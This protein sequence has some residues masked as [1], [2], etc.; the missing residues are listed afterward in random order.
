MRWRGFLIWGG[1]AVAAIALAAGVSV[2]AFRD[3]LSRYSL[4]PS[5]EFDA[6]RAPKAPDY[7]TDQAWVQLPKAPLRDAD[8]FFLYPT[9]YFAGGSWNAP[10]EDQETRERLDTALLPLFA[11]PFGD[12]ANV[13][14]PLYR[15][16]APYAFMTSAQSA[17]QARKLAYGDV[18]AAFDQFLKTRNGQRPFILA[19]YGQGALY[20]V[21]LLREKVA[22]DDAVRAR[23]VAAYF[24]DHALPAVLVTDYL[25]PLTVCAEPAQTGCVVAWQTTMQ[26]ARTDIHHRN[27]PVWSPE[28]TFDVTRGRQLA[29]VNPLTWTSGGRAGTPEMNTG[30]ASADQSAPAGVRLSARVTGADCWNGLLTVDALPDPLFAFAGPRYRDLFPG[31]VNLFYDNIRQNVAARLDAYRES[32]KPP[33]DDL[34]AEEA[35]DTPAPADGPAEP[36]KDPAAAP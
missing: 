8:V 30:A 11:G 36:Q 13:F 4:K 14:A 28:G 26:G 12:H 1:I 17:L 3:N 21:R 33:A 15:Q 20:G 32:L 24:I 22:G 6:A 2:Y 5:G 19:A 31:Q 16:A 35:P 10:I 29:C 9:A 23:L 18:A 34:P 27:A 25:S 7:A